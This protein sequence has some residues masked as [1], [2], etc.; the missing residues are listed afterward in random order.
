M[1]GIAGREDTTDTPSKGTIGAPC[2]L[3]LT[4][5]PSP[6]QTDAAVASAY[7]EVCGPTLAR[8]MQDAMAVYHMRS[9]TP[10][11]DPNNE[12][13]QAWAEANYPDYS[14]F[15][16]PAYGTASTQSVSG[17]SAATQTTP[18]AATA[19]QT[20]PAAPM[21]MSLVIWW[22]AHRVLACL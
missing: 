15:L 10:L 6:T 17:S 22:V 14:E 7:A 21:A 8:Q 4:L 1:P 13:F 16:G 2:T 5:R 19:T 9:R 18:A 11:A 3:S 12:V 20:T